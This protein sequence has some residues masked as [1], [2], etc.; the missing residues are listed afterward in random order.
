MKA[1]ILKIFW[2][3]ILVSL[4]GLTLACMMGYVTFD[5]LIG[6][7]SIF[8]FV[9]LTTAF[10]IS[11][12]MRGIRSLAL[13]F[14]HP[15]SQLPSHLT[16]P[17]SSEWHRSYHCFSIPAQPRHPFLRWLLP[18]PKAVGMVNPGLVPDHNHRYPSPHRPDQS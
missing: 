14:P 1:N 11:Y 6:P 13:A 12:F 9:G 18:E 7:T 4:V 16:Q 10:F 8:I 5:H 3:T 17:R 15:R 2:G